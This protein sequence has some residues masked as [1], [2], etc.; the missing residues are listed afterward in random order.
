MAND[1]YVHQAYLRHFADA[2]E[3]LFAFNKA[4]GTVFNPTVRNIA[5]EQGFHDLPPDNPIGLLA[6]EWEERMTKLESVISPA[7]ENL[8]KQLEAS[9]NIDLASVMGPFSIF[10]T[11]QIFRTRDFRNT[12]TSILKSLRDFLKPFGTVYL[13]G[14]NTPIDLSKVEENECID[15]AGLIFKT[16]ALEEHS[17]KLIDHIWF[18]GC[19]TTD[20][21]FFTSDA[22]VARVFHNPD[23]YMGSK[24][25][26]V[27]GIEIALPLSPKFILVLADR[28][29]WKPIEKFEG[30][31]VA[32]DIDKVKYYNAL[33]VWWSRRQVYC[34]EDKFDQVREMN[35]KNPALA[36][37]NRPK[38]EM[39]GGG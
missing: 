21:P 23:P 9:P 31:V 17:I 26:G 19:N 36:D 38:V 2:N 35:A 14:T 22:P 3:K 27:S 37:I 12:Q 13:G 29:F 1:H 4:Q 10:I 5:S 28:V 6:K 30:R 34:S 24:L 20:Q 39:R 11:L 15:H 32:F 18:V 25:A 16:P 7:H 33:Q 8:L